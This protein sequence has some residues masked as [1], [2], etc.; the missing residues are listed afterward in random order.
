MAD[1]DS[2]LDL[3]GAETP[4]MLNSCGYASITAWSAAKMTVNLVVQKLFV[5]VDPEV[6]SINFKCGR[7][8]RVAR[9][10]RSCF[11][12]RS[13][14]TADVFGMPRVGYIMF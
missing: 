1:F 8:Q 3:V 9:K 4:A 7:G 14:A 10:A 2:V 12:L 5:F 11:S 13:S 6:G